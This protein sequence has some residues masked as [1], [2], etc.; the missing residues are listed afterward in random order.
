MPVGYARVSTA[1]RN[2]A[3]QRDAPTERNANAFLSS[4]VRL[5]DGRRRRITR[6]LLS[7]AQAIYDAG[8]FDP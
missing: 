7:D 4:I 1:D 6:R 3:V 2:L 5:I 8:R